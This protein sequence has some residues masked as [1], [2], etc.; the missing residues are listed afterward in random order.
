MPKDAVEGLSL[1]HPLTHPLTRWLA[2]MA[3]DKTCM[4]LARS[5]S[6]FLSLSGAVDSF[7]SPSSLLT[8]AAAAAAA[9]F[10]VAAFF[11]VVVIAY[12]LLQEK[13]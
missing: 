11:V 3:Q 2:Q 8:T 4:L 9:A 6:L 12:L 10:A 7:S 13:G 5:L 1:T